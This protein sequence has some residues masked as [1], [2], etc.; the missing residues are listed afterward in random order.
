MTAE[1]PAPDALT[2]TT[3]SSVRISSRNGPGW[4]APV[5]RS[6]IFAVAVKQLLA[7]VASVFGT[8]Q[9]SCPV[10]CHEGR[11]LAFGA[12]PRLDAMCS[13][14][15]SLERHRLM[16]LWLQRNEVL[17]AG[18][19]VLHFAPDAS[20]QSVLRG[21]VG[22]YIGADIVAAPGCRVLDIE[23]LAL[24]NASVEMI[25]CSHVLEH[26]DDRKALCEVRRV[27]AKGGLALIMVPVIHGWPESYENPAV[28]TPAD[29]LHHFGQD[30]HLRYYG[31]DIED[32]IVGAGFSV[33]RFTAQEPD[34]LTYSLIR[35]DT[36]YVATV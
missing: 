4:A 35:G 17:W 26:V 10:C 14:C 31:D 6:R 16:A 36:L 20:V 18:R 7:H 29:R 28:T 22:E 32:R 3:K 8:S 13:Y 5:S 19:N 15:G 21:K 24:E 11:F 25:V 2:Q 30:D 9:R 12:P 27:L 34:C 23:A 1:A 33:T